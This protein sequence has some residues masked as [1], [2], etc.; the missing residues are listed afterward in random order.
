[1]RSS[2]LRRK[3]FNDLLSYR[4]TEF[5]SIYENSEEVIKIFYNTCYLRKLCSHVELLSVDCSLLDEIIFKRT[6]E[7][8]LFIPTKVWLCWYPKKTWTT[9]GLLVTEQHDIRLK[10]WINNTSTARV[11]GQVVEVF[12]ARE[13]FR[14][15]TSKIFHLFWALSRI[16][17]LNNFELLSVWKFW[18]REMKFEGPENVSASVVFISC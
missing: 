8:S 15:S 10:F 1:M 3:K 18:K 4:K 12:E 16:F 5:S 7:D 17:N 13:N 6:S 9:S 14:G 11:F 2:E